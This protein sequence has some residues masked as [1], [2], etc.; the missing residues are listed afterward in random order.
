[1]I[2]RFNFYDLYGYAIPGLIL[3]VLLWVPYG[4]STGT[5]PDSDL[6][7]AVLAVVIG[8]AIGHVVQILGQAA[9]PSKLRPAR[10]PNSPAQPDARH[11]SDLIFDSGDRTLSDPVKQRVAEQISREFHLDVRD[12]AFAD[13]DEGK[14]RRAQVRNDAFLLC[15]AALSRSERVSYAEQFEGMYALMRG[16]TAALAIGG[17]FQAGWA[18]KM[19]W[20]RGQRA[21]QVTEAVC[22]VL[23]V[24]IA[25]AMLMLVVVRV[26]APFGQPSRIDSA[27]LWCV[28]GLAAVIGCLSAAITIST[29]ASATA[30]IVVILA[31]TSFFA[32]F[33]C[34]RSHLTF[35]RLFAA[36]VYR[37]FLL[38]ETSQ[39][40]RADK[41]KPR[42]SL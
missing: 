38:V 7:S 12:G 4:I 11:P 15:R 18:A 40:Q 33:L 21:E 28:C 24:L 9:L 29:R 2:D 13:D 27:W 23:F 41:P 20:F 31:A 6:G 39:D 1:M 35:A 10:I 30:W 32:A 3:G 8:Y 36:T 42:G 16:L 19:A 5:V 26:R 17:S 22:I 14:K 34:R 25:A 37:D